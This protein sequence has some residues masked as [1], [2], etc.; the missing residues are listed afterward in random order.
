MM[1][2]QRLVLCGVLFM[3]PLDTEAQ[4]ADRD[5]LPPYLDPDLDAHTRV[6]DLLGRMTLEEKVVQLESA[7]PAIPR[8]G[9]PEYNWWNECLHGVARAGLATV[10]PQA[11]GLGATWDGD[12]VF[13]VATATSDEA[14]AKHHE[15]LRNGS[16]DIYEGLTFWSP[17]INIFRDPRW[18]RGQE[19]YGEDPYL[20]G[21]LGVAFVRGLQGDD[22]HYLK[23]VA[24][25]KHFAVHS[26]PE[27]LR[28]TFDAVVDERDLRETYLPAFR[29]CVVEAKAQS[30]MCAYNRFRGSPCCGSAP[31]LEKILRDE[32]GFDGYVVSDCGAVQDIYMRH[33]VAGSPPEAAASALKAGT[34]L[35]CG[36]QYRHLVEA[37]RTGLVEEDVVDTAVTRLFTAR[38]KLGM[39]DPPER[40]PFAQIPYAVVDSKEHR[41]LSRTAARK[42]IVLLRND[43]NTLPLRK[44]VKTVAVIG[45][46]A[47]VADVLFGN[48]NGMP[49]YSVTPLAGIRHAVSTGTKV[50]YAPGCDLAEGYATLRV[51]PAEF[52]RTTID[53]QQT[54]GLRGEYFDSP[55]LTGEPVM[56]RADRVVDMNWRVMAPDTRLKGRDYTVRWSGELIPPVSGLYTIGTEGF[57][58][59]RLFVDDSLITEFQGKHQARMIRRTIPLEKGQRCRVRLDFF[60]RS[61]G[62]FMRLLWGIAGDPAL[63]PEAVSAAAEADVAVMVLGLSPA[64]EGEESPV[65]LRGFV[66]GD[67]DR[68][69]LPE[70]QEHLLRKIHSTGTPVVVVLLSGSALSLPWADRHVAAILEA[71]YPGQE[72]GNAIADVLFG[73]YNP[74]GRLPVTF[75]ESVEDLPPFEEYHMAGRTYRY[76]TGKALYGFGHGL[77]YT[78]FRYNTLRVPS[79]VRK[80]DPVEIRVDLTNTGSRDGEEVVQVYVSQSGKSGH[81]P[82][83]AL[84]GFRRVSLTAGERKTIAFTLSPNQYALVNA[85]GQ[86]E[87]P[88][89]TFMISVGGKQPGTPALSEA[90]TTAVVT[91]V[92]NVVE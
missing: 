42:S 21:R 34:D 43:G 80:G 11:I 41:E 17:N 76:F 91:S 78:T 69:S 8:L 25:P 31:L 45:P 68:I 37:V 79:I 75:Y 22:P 72:G 63:L 55:D 84:Q 64:L 28:H 52:L 85:D 92:V 50:V 2:I 18:G 27:P 26:G 32:W 14:R 3:L 57:G 10:F 61:S 51:I 35:N 20:T 44:D 4:I 77:S 19:T 71:W 82:I 40:I 74:A 33:R 23:L 29:A 53:G 58:G 66:R 30:V 7:A 67:R 60:S 1:L 87:R 73:D 70:P 6:R 24:T 89:G 86:W 47:D 15:F 38:M 65:E 56:M 9:I 16:R 49:S 46:N 59:Y 12:L 62:S 81:S 13:Q 39:F 48:Y 36:N 83:R 5:S 90:S 54:N 88:L